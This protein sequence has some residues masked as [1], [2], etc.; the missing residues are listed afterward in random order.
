M[1]A[2]HL[3]E[4]KK[5]YYFSEFKDGS[6]TN[7]DYIIWKSTWEWKSYFTMTYAL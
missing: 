5:N 6:Y 1:I 3:F 2:Q 7:M 4:R